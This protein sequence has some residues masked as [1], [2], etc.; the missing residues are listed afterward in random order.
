MTKHNAILGALPALDALGNLFG[1]KGVRM[2]INKGITITVDIGHFPDARIPYRVFA[3]LPAVLGTDDFDV[4][5]AT[6]NA[7]SSTRLEL[8]IPGRANDG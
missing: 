5:Y 7:S 8:S 1:T 2:A 4:Y 6:G 3:G